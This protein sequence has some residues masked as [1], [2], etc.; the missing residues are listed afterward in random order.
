MSLSISHYLICHWKNKISSFQTIILAIVTKQFQIKILLLTIKISVLKLRFHHHPTIT[1][2]PLQQILL[3]LLKRQKGSL[4]D[5]VV[6]VNNFII[7]KNTKQK[8]TWGFT[9]TDKSSSGQFWIWLGG[10]DHTSTPS[11]SR[12]HLYIPRI[13]IIF[14]LFLKLMKSIFNKK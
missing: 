8:K 10:L 9:L 11:Q 3:C 7:K 1:S 4:S 6:P 13:I 14:V 2:N 5:L 12:R